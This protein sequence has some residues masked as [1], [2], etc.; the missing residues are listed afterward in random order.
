MTDAARAQL[1]QR[2]RRFGQ[3]ALAQPGAGELQHCAVRLATPD[4]QR[5]IVYGILLRTELSA[6]GI[7][8][9][10]AAVCTERPSLEAARFTATESSRYSSSVPAYVTSPPI[11]STCAA[12]DRSRA[13][14]DPL[15]SIAAVV[16][17]GRT[18]SASPS[19]IA[20]TSS[21]TR[22][23]AA[24]TTSGGVAAAAAS[25]AIARSTR[26]T[27]WASAVSRSTACASA[28]PAPASNLDDS[29]NP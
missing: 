22:I 15:T 23:A 3:P 17:P 8:G 5:R 1:A 14:S 12:I 18:R 4:G 11:A 28:A 20:A 26:N 6:Q 25:R 2:D 21:S 29:M 24:C 13:A 19:R 9:E 16:S 10:S 7:T 27:V